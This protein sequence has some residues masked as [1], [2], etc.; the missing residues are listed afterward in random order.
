MEPVAERCIQLI[1][2]VKRIPAATVSLTSTF[3]ELGFDSLDK[4][5]LAF[6]IEEAFSIEIPESKLAT[7][8]TVADI[9]DGVSAAV[10]AKAGPGLPPENQP[11]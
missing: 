6:D 9:V 8:K 3:D 2:D 5:S 1:S 11:A 10:A 4:T 7:I